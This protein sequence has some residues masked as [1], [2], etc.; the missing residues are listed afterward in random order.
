VD[1]KSVQR[2]NIVV[3]QQ[4]RV[5]MLVTWGIEWSKGGMP[6][7][8]S[9]RNFSHRTWAIIDLGDHDLF[10]IISD[11]GSPQRV[12]L[13]LGSICKI[14]F[15]ATASNVKMRKLTQHSSNRGIPC[16]V[17]DLGPFRGT[18]DQPNENQSG[19]FRC[20]ADVFRILHFVR[21]TGHVGWSS[22]KFVIWVLCDPQ[23][24][25]AIIALAGNWCCE[26]NH[27]R[28]EFILL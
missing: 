28:F 7:R 18:W 1:T 10:R 2:I 20:T 17:Y 21:F 27:Q 16:F 3:L 9:F 15:Q 19:L 11:P 12:T 5:N 22:E 14:P 8:H 6:H 4:L 13:L 25:G 24:T 26:S 23:T